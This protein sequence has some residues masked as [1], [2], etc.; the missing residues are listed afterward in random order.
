MAAY[1]VNNNLDGTAYNASYEMQIF[2]AE[3][4]LITYKEG[5]MTIPPHR[6]TLAF[7]GAVSTGKR[8]P[9]KAII[10]I[11]PPQWIKETISSAI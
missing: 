3:G 5:S 11:D 10:T 8:I 1:V 6:N 9:A 2:D 7:Q 4:V